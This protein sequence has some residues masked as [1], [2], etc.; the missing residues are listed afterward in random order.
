MATTPAE[1]SQMSTSIASFAPPSITT[2]GSDCVESLTLWGSSSCCVDVVSTIV[3]LVG[4]ELAVQVG[5]TL[6]S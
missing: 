4:L 5:L 2:A 3:V 1:C 6:N